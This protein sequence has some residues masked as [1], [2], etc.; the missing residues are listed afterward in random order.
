MKRFAVN[1][2]LFVVTVAFQ[3]SAVPS[4]PGAILS[5]QRRFSLASSCHLRDAKC[6]HGSRT[7]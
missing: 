6:G 3:W 5:K 1:V 2:L 7:E 4:G